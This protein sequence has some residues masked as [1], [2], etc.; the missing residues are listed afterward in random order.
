MGCADGVGDG[1][2]RA[3][4]RPAAARGRA[5][6]EPRSGRDPG[7]AWRGGGVRRSGPA[8]LPGSREAIQLR[9][10]VGLLRRVEG[11]D[12]WP[13]LGDA[14]LLAGLDEWLAPHLDGIT[15]TARL[16]RLDMAAILNDRLDWQQRRR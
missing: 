8:V 15:Q 4:A 3:P 5:L 13:D 9:A 7:G 10:R 14:A 11:E 6:A 1:T 12:A 16:A 2:A